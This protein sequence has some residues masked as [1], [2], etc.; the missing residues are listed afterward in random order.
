M[1][2]KFEWHLIHKYVLL[3]I[4]YFFLSKTK[5]NFFIVTEL[6][7]HISKWDIILENYLHAARK[8]K[9]KIL[10]YIWMRKFRICYFFTGKCTV[11]MRAAEIMASWCVHVPLCWWTEY[12]RFA[13]LSS[14]SSMKKSLENLPP[15]SIITLCILHCAESHSSLASQM[16]KQSSAVTSATGTAEFKLRSPPRLSFKQNL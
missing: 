4:F 3:L 1:N 9:G 12:T 5:F 13:S 6:Q 16:W 11:L 10:K 14:C 2:F 7:I 8:S 15:N